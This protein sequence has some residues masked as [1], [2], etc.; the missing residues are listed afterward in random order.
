VIHI[1]EEKMKL[2]APKMGTFWLAVIIAGL[3]LLSTLVS[4][5]LLSPYA[6]WLVV[7]GFVILMLSVLVKDL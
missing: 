2:S 1:Q 5:P 3:G 4:I 6:F 7:I